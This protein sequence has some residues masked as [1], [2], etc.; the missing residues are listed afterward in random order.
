M[1]PLLIPSPS[2]MENELTHTGSEKAPMRECLSS[3]ST[4]TDHS[5]TPAIDALRAVKPGPNPFGSE[6]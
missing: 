3:L 4:F 5:L 1:S 2:L 6:W